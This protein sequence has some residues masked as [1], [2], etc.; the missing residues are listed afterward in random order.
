[1][2][3]SAEPGFE[4][5]QPGMLTLIQ[6]LG[7]FGF[8]GIGLSNGGPLDMLAFRWANRLCGN[9][10]NATALEASIG[11]LVLQVQVYSVVAVTGADMPFTINGVEKELWCSHK[12]SPGDRLE[13]G[14]SLRGCRSYLAVA[15]GFDIAKAFFS[16][17]TVTRENIGG[18]YGEGLK[19]GDFLPCAEHK[20]EPL[21]RLSEADRPTYGD[22]ISLRVIPGYQY[23]VFSE[24]QQRIFY[25]N[26]YIVSA[27]SNRMGYCLEGTPVTASIGGILSE[28]ICHGAIQIPADGQ[29]IVLLNDR[30]T[31]GGYPKIGSA[32]SIDTAR[33]AQ[34][35]PGAKVS[36]EQVSMEQAHN[37]LHL[38]QSRF[39]NASLE[40]VH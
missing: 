4:V 40:R 8:H 14:F 38:Q 5:L 24:L 20:G 6:D 37:L 9:H 36:F 27:R 22:D 29:P 23:K 28:G 32:I 3:S 15:G 26:E 35:L 11:G 7:R 21:W 39:H 33:L 19:P 31:I 12:V 16:T 34:L 10:D 30:Q 18:L 1:M 13:L 2:N 17:A 25:S